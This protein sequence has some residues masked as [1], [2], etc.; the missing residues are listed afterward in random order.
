MNRNIGKINR[1]FQTRVFEH[2]SKWVH[3]AIKLYELIIA[4]EKHSS[5]SVAE[6]ID[7]ER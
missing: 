4:T 3:K 1:N 6:H 2:L 7:G 5:F